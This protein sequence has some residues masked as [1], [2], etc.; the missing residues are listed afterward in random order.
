MEL[1]CSVSLRFL[2]K[3][4]LFCQGTLHLISHALSGVE[5]SGACSGPASDLNGCR[6]KPLH[7]IL[8][9]SCTSAKA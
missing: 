7:R 9:Y 3:P 5:L 2:S 8:F 6:D 1:H 4:F